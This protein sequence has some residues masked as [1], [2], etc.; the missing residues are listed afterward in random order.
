MIGVEEEDKT[1]PEGGNIVL[2]REEVDLRS[3]PG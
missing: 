3:N 2:E 1:N